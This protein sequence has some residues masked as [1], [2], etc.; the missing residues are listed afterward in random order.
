MVS[1]KEVFDHDFVV[2][3]DH[4]IM[5]FHNPCIPNSLNFIGKPMPQ[6]QFSTF[7]AG[8]LRTDIHL[9]YKETWVFREFL[10]AYMPLMSSFV[11]NERDEFSRIRGMMNLVRDNQLDLWRKWL[12]WRK[13]MIDFAGLPG[14]IALCREYG[15]ETFKFV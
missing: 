5:A 6:E 8:L 13:Y 10:K 3:P 9:H 2:V 4:R 11:W 15:K 1:K 7:Y 14:E 12:N